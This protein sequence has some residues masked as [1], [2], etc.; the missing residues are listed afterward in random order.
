MVFRALGADRSRPGGAIHGDSGEG[1][2]YPLGEGE[3]VAL[4]SPA[5]PPQVGASADDMESR[6][7]T[8]NVHRCLPSMSVRRGEPGHSTSDSRSAW[9]VPT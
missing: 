7:H 4:R 3:A 8:E 6:A 2:T 1:T 5:E 9:L